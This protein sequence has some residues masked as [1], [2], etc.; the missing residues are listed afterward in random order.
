[1]AV[2]YG[3]V[4]RGY[5]PSSSKNKYKDRYEYDV[6]VSF[7]QGQQIIPNVRVAGDFDGPDD[8]SETILRG[9]QDEGGKGGYFSQTIKDAN[10]QVGTRVIVLF[11][12]DSGKE[13]RY[14]G[15][16]ISTI[17]HPKNTTLLNTGS[18]TLLP[19]VTKENSSPQYRRKFNGVFSS[20]DELG[21]YRLQYNG[22]A[23][24]KPNN[25]TSSVLPKVSSFGQMTM[26]FLQKS[27]FRLVDN[28]S[29]GLVVD[30]FGKY[31]SLN[32]TTVPPTTKYGD[33]SSV[34]IGEVSGTSVPKGQEVRLDKNAN[35]L[36]LRSAG[37][38]N[39]I[40]T[41]NLSKNTKNIIDTK[42]YDLTDNSGST[43]QITGGTI[44][45]KCNTF[46]IKATNIKATDSVATL[47]IGGGKVAL[48]TPAAEVITLAIQHIQTLITNAPVLTITPVGPGQLNPVV[49]TALTAIQTL[50]QSIKK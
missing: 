20:V 41:N 12:G 36:W 27:V 10:D 13:N 14:S 1:M 32:N 21:Q 48:G 40:S 16:I 19:S 9:S 34:S 25:N 11:P 50:L 42:E 33:S 29:Q 7:S 8:F 2:Y 38:L 3:E 28:N 22:L 37:D 23:I 26:D 49:I 4:L 46:E 39:L 5:P 18:N 45:S 15:F 30:S 44:S 17:G 31:V 24:I 43:I 47:S 6:L 35:V